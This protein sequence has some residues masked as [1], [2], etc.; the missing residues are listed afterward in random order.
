MNSAAFFRI[1]LVFTVFSLV[2]LAYA[3]VP[4]VDFG[5]MGTVAVAGSFIGL[6]LYSS[7]STHTFNPSA[8]TLVS[9]AANGTI[10]SIAWTNV[11]GSILAGCILNNVL[12]I[13]GNFSSLSGQAYANVAAYDLSSRSFRALG[14][15]LDDA[16]D[17]LYCDSSASQVWAGGRFRHPVNVDAL[18]YGGSVV[19]YDVKSST[20]Q[21]PAF[22]G[23]TGT[24][25]SVRSI[26]PSSSGSSL[27]FGGSFTTNYGVNV[28]VAN[29]TNNPNVPYST[30]ASPFSSSLVPLPLAPADVVASPSSSEDGFSNISNIVCPA[31]PDGPGNTWFSANNARTLITIRT[32]KYTTARGVRLGNTFLPNHG[33]RTFQVVTI[34]DNNP[35]KLTYIDPTTR[36]NVSCTDSCPLMTDSSI[37]YQDFLFEMADTLT[38]VQIT[39]LEWEG[40]SAGLHLLQVLSDGAFASALN[41]DNRASCYSPSGSSV[42]L[43]GTWHAENVFT[44]IAATTQ[45]VLVAKPSVGTPPSNSPSVT[46]HPYVSA[47]GY[48]DVY[49]YIPGC[50]DMQDC[51]ARTS[52]KLTTNPGGG[53]LPVEKTVSQNV[54]ADTRVQIY[55]G[56]IA[57]FP[58]SYTSSVKLTLADQPTGNG[59]HG[60]YE[61]IADRVQ[62]VLISLD[63]TVGGNNGTGGLTTSTTGFGFFEWTK[64]GN[65]NATGVLPNTTETQLDQLS[66][67]LATA[68]GSTTRTAVVNALVANSD[69]QVFLGGLF[70]VTNGPTNV[71]EFKDAAIIPLSNNGLNG[72]VNGLAIA[73]NSLFVGGAFTDVVSGSVEGIRGIAKYDYGSSSWAPL[74]GGVNGVVVTLV[75]ANGRLVLTGNFTEVYSSVDG[76]GSPADGLAIWDLNGGEWVKQ[77]GAFIGSTSL[78]VS[79][80]DGSSFIAGNIAAANEFSASGWT[81]I[82]SGTNGQPSFTSTPSTLDDVFPSGTNPSPSHTPAARRW[83]KARLDTGLISWLFPRLKAAVLPRQSPPAPG[84]LPPLPPAPAPAVLA[85]A[86]WTNSSSKHQNVILGGNFTFVDNSRTRYSGVSIYDVKTQFIHGL[87]GDA[88]SGVVYS[89]LV[90]DDTLFVGG[91]LTVGNTPGF[92]I[93]DLK[94]NQWSSLSLVLKGSP[95]VRSITLRPTDS[96]TVIVA[97][98]F[99]GAGSTTCDAICAWD[100]IHQQWNTLGSGI[101]GQVAAVDYSEGILVAGGYITLSDG[102]SA[103][104]AKYDF[105][106]STWAAIG[107]GL[108]GPVTA[109]R[110][111]DKN[112]NS[113]FVAGKSADE[114]SFLA[115]WDGS[116]WNII[117]GGLV[118]ST[119]V[120]QL[121]L[122]PLRD[123]HIANNVLAQDRAL[124]IS[125]TLS[126]STFG[127]VS[128][129]LFDGKSFY[130]YI[131]SISGSGAQGVIAGF[132]HSLSTFSSASRHVLGVG[133][134]ILIS[135]AISAGIVFFLL[136]VGILLTLFSRESTAID[137]K[138]WDQ[139]ENE[140]L[141]PSSLLEHVNAAT[142][143]AIIGN[144]ALAETTSPEDDRRQAPS[145]GSEEYGTTEQDHDGWRRAE[146]PAVPA[147]ADYDQ[148]EEGRLAHVRYSFEGQGE[149][150]LP[151]E[152][153]TE[154]LVLDDRDAAWWYVR[155]VATGR[156]GVVPAAYLY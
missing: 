152:T 122:V 124:L 60:N 92:A 136:L 137:P 29:G 94:N 5:R 98:T 81:L 100:V 17:V 68:L 132:F 3:D 130:P 32:N 93:Y 57:T 115:Y 50:D 138:D 107:S 38:G 113:I 142:R 84:G 143:S 86:F 26:V 139:D 51:A 19:V 79:V 109:L 144:A 1:R 11:G 42:D 118:Q 34:P 128:S 7:N 10:N 56:Y 62:Y 71:V 45:T 54:H 39:L 150:E 117:D 41:T 59:F 13:G 33:T 65:V 87:Q 102:T 2:T 90:Q 80:S 140:S 85:A 67:Q 83:N 78:F 12:Y 134:V 88:I 52:V 25:P 6:G 23:L 108:P 21:P 72:V 47:S 76:Y 111:N 148:E 127:N 101:H 121:D 37:P 18:S 135:I 155:D 156:E 154:L 103:N 15:G 30:G 99:T 129:A 36:A 105:S 116:S 61:I 14:S 49:L 64:Q 153:G 131:T 16:V 22:T 63:S 48:Y 43:T 55:S 147:G 9:R 112:L 96:N 145:R 20:W 119:T 70:G 149:G 74:G 133:V 69:G 123:Q 97:G 73:N 27:Y 24:S 151:L 126:S 89:L 31:G 35:L 75:V 4:R 58:P 146:T 40:S 44:T 82:Q 53:A 125:G 104:V 141:R 95:F 114:T 91:N 106:S 77:N 66:T 46:W 28:T 120:S 8:S 110:I